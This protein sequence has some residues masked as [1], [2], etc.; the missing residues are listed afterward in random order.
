[1]KFFANA[2][3][4]KK[5][6]ASL[7]TMENS[8]NKEL[9]CVRVV[10]ST[11]GDFVKLHRTNLEMCEE[12]TIQAVITEDGETFMDAKLLKDNIN[13]L[14]KK[15]KLV[16][17]QTEPDG[18][19]SIKD[20]IGCMTSYAEC[21]FYDEYPDYPKKDE[22]KHGI[23]VSSSVL[24]N[25]L[26]KTIFSAQ[27]E[28]HNPH[29]RLIHFEFDSLESVAVSTDSKRMSVIR[30]NDIK[31][32]EKVE[33]NL[34]LDAAKQL[35]KLLRK[36]K[37]NVGIEI[38]KSGNVVFNLADCQIVTRVMD[39]RFP[40]YLRVIPKEASHK[41]QISRKDFL[42]NLK[43]LHPASKEFSNM[44]Q[45]IFT[46]EELTLSVQSGS[47]IKMPAKSS[48]D[49]DFSFHLNGSML[50]EYLSAEDEDVIELS[51]TTRNYPIECRPYDK[52]YTGNWNQYI[53]MPMTN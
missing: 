36:D 46:S 42:N 30:S 6:V 49:P 35:E 23:D 21:F 29:Q 51:G 4:F 33:I 8:M 16:Y 38:Q 44:I 14:D 1:M 5:A 11:K 50:I 19:I 27:N 52:E 53:Q 3:L 28:K 10:A 20:D 24:H 40:N 47:S 43:K 2:D 15:A 32:M 26:K 17:F 48:L 41:Y 22:L 34:P 31:S 13:A 18:R 9:N 45:F 37:N 39:V 12:F 25:M 7:H